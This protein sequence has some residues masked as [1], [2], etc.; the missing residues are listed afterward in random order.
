MK[1]KALIPLEV[2]RRLDQEQKLR[3]LQKTQM[4][5]KIVEMENRNYQRSVSSSRDN[6]MIEAL[7]K[8]RQSKVSH[9]EDFTRMQGNWLHNQSMKD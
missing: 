6:Y 2:Q 8:V 5:E 1:D 4:E 7:K 9:H 3:N